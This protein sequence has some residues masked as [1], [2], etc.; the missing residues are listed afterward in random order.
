MDVKELAV[1]V[2][3]YSSVVEQL[4]STYEALQPA[5]RTDKQQHTI[6]VEAT[7]LSFTVCIF[8]QSLIII[9]YQ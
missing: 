9:L 8:T 1:G 7:A 4:S 3:G 2:E 6:G 5:P